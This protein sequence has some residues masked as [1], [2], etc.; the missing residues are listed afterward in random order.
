MF[1]KKTKIIFKKQSKK[2]PIS[3]I[4]T[5][6]SKLQKPFLKWVGGKTQM[7]TSLL[8]KFPI[9]IENYHELFLGGGSVLLSVLSLQKMGK[10]TINN[11]INA[12]DLNKGLINTFNQIKNVPLELI[13]ELNILKKVFIDIKINSEGQR[14]KPSQINDSTCKKTREHYYYWIRDKFNNESKDT[15]QSASYFIFLNKTGFRGMYREGKS[16]FNIPYGLKD[17]ETIPTIF[18]EITINKISQLIQNVNF[19]MMSF[20]DSIKNIKKKDFVYLDP[21]YAPENAKSFVGYLHNGFNLEEHK[22]LFNKIKNLDGV[23]FVMSN[24]KVDLVTNTFKDFKCEDIIA[25]RAINSKNPGST[26]TEI[27]I[28]N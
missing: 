18:N 15:L 7:I 26:T 27:I 19:Y 11:T 25:R 5:N 23:K 14:G 10:I 1:N 2:V 4:E 16:G 17:K 3:F 28:Y 12:F 22:L 20:K 13:K 24:A 8:S 21:P 9:K 6:K